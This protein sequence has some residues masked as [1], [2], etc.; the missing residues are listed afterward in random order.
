MIELFC[1]VN[2]SQQLQIK[3]VYIQMIVH[4]LCYVANAPRGNVQTLRFQPK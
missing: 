3:H 4:S 2:K 1:V